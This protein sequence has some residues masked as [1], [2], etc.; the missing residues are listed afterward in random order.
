[1]KHPSP[2]ES[3]RNGVFHLGVEDLPL[4]G[5]E[6]TILDTEILPVFHLQQYQNTLG[7]KK[8][9][10]KYVY[11]EKEREISLIGVR[12]KTFRWTKTKKHNPKKKTNREIP[13]FQKNGG[14]HSGGVFP[15]F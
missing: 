9:I 7:R 8:K 3:N 1:M 10:Y 4:W 5:C 2:L 14:A 11:S 13:V 6:Q 12:K 15:Q